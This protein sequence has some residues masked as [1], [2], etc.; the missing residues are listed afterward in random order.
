[1]NKPKT[2]KE[3]N[4]WSIYSPA[5]EKKLIFGWRIHCRKGNE[6]TSWPCW[7]GERLAFKGCGQVG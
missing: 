1:L 2:K 3:R 6:T 7:R 5:L 4:W